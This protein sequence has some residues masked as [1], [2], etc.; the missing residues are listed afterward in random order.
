MFSDL[1]GVPLG[2][3]SFDPYNFTSCGDDSRKAI[4]QCLA[5]QMILK[6]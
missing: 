1:L 2:I 3:I 6:H 5:H 4:S